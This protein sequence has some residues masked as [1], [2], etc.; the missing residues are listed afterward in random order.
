MQAAE[1]LYQ[2][3]ILSLRC[4]G[5]VVKFGLVDTTSDT[6]GNHFRPN[7]TSFDVFQLVSF[8]LQMLF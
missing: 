4:A 8:N 1:V 3:D 2:N 7:A 5:Y 6:K